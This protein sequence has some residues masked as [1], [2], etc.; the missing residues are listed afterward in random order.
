MLRVPVVIFNNLQLTTAVAGATSAVPDAT[1]LT[2]ISAATVNNTTAGAVTLDAYIVPSGGTA[3]VANQ[4]ISA[5]SIPA[6]GSTPT[7]LSALI[8]QTIPAGGTLQMK[9]SAA[10]SLSPFVSGYRT[11]I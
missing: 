6:A 4:V 10:T 8:G 11:T 1:T 3:G 7:I 2:T 9:A 5:L